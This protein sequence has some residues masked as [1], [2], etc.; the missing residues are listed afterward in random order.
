MTTVSVVPCAFQRRFLR[1][2]P[3]ESGG[4]YK[5][6]Y[7]PIDVETGRIKGAT[8]DD[9]GTWTME[10]GDVLKDTRNHYVL[11]RVGESWLPAVVS[12]TST[13]IKK[14]KRWMSRIS[15][16][17][18]RTKDGKAFNPASY[19]HVYRIVSVKESNDKGQWFGVDINLVEPVSDPELY[20]KAKAFNAA[21][22]AG[23][24]ETQTPPADTGAGGSADGGERF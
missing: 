24:V 16:I 4:G 15:A 22:N 23:E 13:Q 7:S 18:L 19:S 1:W 3:R 10:D 14:S 17:E 11:A 8:L 5:G 20:A 12:L 9:E 2:T 6:D 21:V